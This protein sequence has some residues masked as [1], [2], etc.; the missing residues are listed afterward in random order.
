MPKLIAIRVRFWQGKGAKIEAQIH[1]KSIQ[2]SMLFSKSF[3]DR[4]LIDF[5]SLW[6]LKMMVSYR[7]GAIFHKIAVS[8]K[9]S[10]NDQCL[11]QKASRNRSKID[12]KSYQK[13]HQFLHRCLIDCWSKMPSKMELQ[14]DQGHVMAIVSP[15]GAFEVVMCSLFFEK[16]SC[17]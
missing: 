17:S 12:Q 7:R 2:K 16:V 9:W 13:S 14:S 11:I 10:K 15:P 1:Q 3:S 8:E 4:F 5:W 6:P